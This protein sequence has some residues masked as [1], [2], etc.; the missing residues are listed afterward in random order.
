M[1]LLFGRFSVPSTKRSESFI[2]KEYRVFRILL[3]SDTHFAPH[4]IFVGKGRKSITGSSNL[5]GGMDPFGSLVMPIDP[6]S[7]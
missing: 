1:Y 2:H 6:F 3:C 5:G 4:W 7:E